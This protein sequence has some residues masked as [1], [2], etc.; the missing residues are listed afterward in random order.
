MELFNVFI[1]IAINAEETMKKLDKIMSALKKFADS[2]VEA[3]EKAAG[4]FK[5]LGD[6]YNSSM[7]W[8]ENLYKKG[9]SWY[10]WGKL[11]KDQIKGLVSSISNLGESF[12]KLKAKLLKIMGPKGWIIAAIGAIIAAVAIWIKNNED[13]QEKLRKVW[14][15]IQNFIGVAVEFIQDIVGRVFGWIQGFIDEHGETITAI[16][17]KVWKAIENVFKTVTSIVQGIVE[18]VFGAIQT[19]IDNHG[20][21][22]M[23]IFGV[24]WDTVK[25]IFDRVV[26]NIQSALRLFT[27]IFQGD[28][29]AAWDEVLSI[30]SRFMD[31]ITDTPSDIVNIGRN[32]IYGL[33][34]GINSMRQW[35]TDK[36]TAFFDS[37]ILGAVTRFLGI[38]SPSKLF[39][40]KVGKMIVKGVA[41]ELNTAL[42]T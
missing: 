35:I 24:V 36:I 11:K 32:L 33:W 4:A 27:A 5:R 40:D 20:E 15:K 14:E 7:K 8:L 25:D 6:S 1:K 41:A 30:G 16:F 23:R 12:V 9:A 29:Q 26:E 38:N 3:C 10:L 18:R 34:N 17:S 28:W 22:I 39:E 2:C 31:S 19:F 37:G 13:A 21:T 42:C